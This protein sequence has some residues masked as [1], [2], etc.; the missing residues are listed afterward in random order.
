[1]LPRRAHDEM[2]T[3]FLHNNASLWF[4]RTNQILGWDE[5]ILPLAP[6]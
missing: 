3:I 4:L 5:T 1:M 2:S 6:T